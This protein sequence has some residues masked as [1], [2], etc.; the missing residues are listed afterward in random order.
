MPPFQSSVYIFLLGQ[1]AFFFF[2]SA[3]PIVSLTLVIQPIPKLR[4]FF[5]GRIEFRDRNLS[6]KMGSKEG[7]T[8]WKRIEMIALEE[9]EYQA[10]RIWANHG[11]TKQGLGYWKW[12][13]G[14]SL[15]MEKQKKR[16]AL[17][18]SI[19]PEQDQL[20]DQRDAE[21]ENPSG[22]VSSIDLAKN[23]ECS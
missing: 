21:P 19:Q 13:E 12:V 6:S 10:G 15:V 3:R 14:Q 18:A 9:P 5:I 7:W 22:R 4:V 11:A 1:G 2:I 20:M 17:K 23:T 8:G 16:P